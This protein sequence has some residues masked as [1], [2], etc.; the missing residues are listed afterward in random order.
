MY[1]SSIVVSS[2]F[3]ATV[4]AYAVPDASFPQRNLYARKAYPEL[5]ERALYARKV[6]PDFEEREFNERD[7]Y[8]STVYS[9]LFPRG[10]DIYA[11]GSAKGG[12]TTT[13]ITSDGPKPDNV[14][15]P[16][17]DKTILK[18][19]TWSVTSEKKQSDTALSNRKKQI[20]DGKWHNKRHAENLKR[21][22]FARAAKAYFE[23]RNAYPEAYLEKRDAYAEAEYKE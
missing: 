3:A 23:E 6:Y 17:P 11:G 19:Q 18:S 13:T 15:V 2:F 4:A 8:A 16:D 1:F 7:V 10:D 14:R 9:D 21:E 12:K 5:K 20:I 22:L